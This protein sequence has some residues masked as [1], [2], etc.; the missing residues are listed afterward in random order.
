MRQKKK[1]KKQIAVPISDKLV[2]LK[3]G[4]GHKAWHKCLDHQQRFNHANSEPLD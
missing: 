3:Q 1:K 2:S 4:Q